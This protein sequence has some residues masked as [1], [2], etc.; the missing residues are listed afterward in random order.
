ME[1]QKSTLLCASAFFLGCAALDVINLIV[2]W[3][4]GSLKFTANVA[5]VPEA[6]ANTA[7]T[8]TFIILLAI[9]SIGTI[10]K[11]Y[12][13]VKGLRQSKGQGGNGRGHIVWAKIIAVLLVIGVIGTISSV[14]Q[15]TEHW[16]TLI[17]PV[18]SLIAAYF[19]I[20]SASALKN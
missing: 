20:K 5:G 13:G 3:A 17:S 2:A 1:K 16:Y 11:L 15:G 10:L 18:I 8:V 14:T 4:N 12:L 19:Y 6:A 7:V 9:G